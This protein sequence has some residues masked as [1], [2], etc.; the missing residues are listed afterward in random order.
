[1]FL[2]SFPSFVSPVFPPFQRLTISVLPASVSSPFYSGSVRLICFSYIP[3]SPLLSIPSSFLLASCSI[4]SNSLYRHCILFGS[5]EL[6]SISNFIFRPHFYDGRCHIISPSPSS[7]YSSFIYLVHLLCLHHLRRISSSR[8][9]PLCRS[10]RTVQRREVGA[11][12]RS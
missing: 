4:T 5:L 3:P 7:Y 6:L 2:H 1:M 10:W 8:D 9:Q 11:V 12:I